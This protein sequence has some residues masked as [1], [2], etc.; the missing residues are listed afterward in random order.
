MFQF[1]DLWK[2]ID[3][4]TKNYIKKSMKTLVVISNKYVKT[5]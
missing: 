2:Q 4:D 5:L 3:T 1:K